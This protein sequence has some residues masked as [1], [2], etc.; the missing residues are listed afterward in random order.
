MVAKAGLFCGFWVGMIVQSPLHGPRLSKS[1]A[2]VL[3]TRIAENVGLE[4]HR[5]GD[6]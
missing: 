2:S 3:E 4:E 5:W 1:I 6:L